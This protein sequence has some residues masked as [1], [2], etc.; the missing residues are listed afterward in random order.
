MDKRLTN[1]YA[2]KKENSKK[3]KICNNE[4]P[5]GS[6]MYYYCYHCGGESDVR[7]ESDFSPVNHIC[8]PCNPL[9]EEKL[10]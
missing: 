10:I 6:P 8:T 9:V 1:F 3:E 5:A 7:S 2:R 4:L